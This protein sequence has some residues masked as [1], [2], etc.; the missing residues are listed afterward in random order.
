MSPK[1]SSLFP[2]DPD[3]SDALNVL[4]GLDRC[5][6]EPLASKIVSTIDPHCTRVEVAGSIRRRKPTVNDIDIVAQ[7]KPQSWLGWIPFMLAVPEYSKRTL[8]GKMDE[9]KS[10]L[11]K[12]TFPYMRRVAGEHSHFTRRDYK[13]WLKH[14]DTNH[15]S[16]ALRRLALLNQT[17]VYLFWRNPDLD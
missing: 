3:A 9:V 15:L 11:A 12:F 5:E 7:P 16:L 1:Q 17:K 4:R 14:A 8:K 10:I 13:E 2:E 6:V